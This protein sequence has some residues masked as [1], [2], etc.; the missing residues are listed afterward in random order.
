MCV[1]I[2][3]TIFV[4]NISRSKQNWARYDQIYV[5][6]LCKV[7]VILVRFWWD[8]NFLDR[9][10]KNTQISNFMEIRPVGAECSMRADGPTNVKKLTV[11]FRN[12]SIASKWT[13]PFD[14]VHIFALH[15][16]IFPVDST[17]AALPSQR[18]VAI[19]KVNLPALKTA[20]Y[21]ETIYCDNCHH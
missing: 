2:F 1:L 21:R 9:F 16:C 13:Y 20:L 7:P 6:S 12:F 19:V 15:L 11:A 14:T 18:H 5:G 10:S 3:S 8:L 17:I 4:W